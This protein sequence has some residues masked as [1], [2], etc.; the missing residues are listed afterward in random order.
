MR[1]WQRSLSAIVSSRPYRYF[2]LPDNGFPAYPT[3][4]RM[5]L[6]S[7]VDNVPHGCWF[8]FGHSDRSEYFN[9]SLNTNLWGE[10][11]E[12]SA[13]TSIRDR[14]KEGLLIHLETRIENM[15]RSREKIR[16]TPTSAFPNLRPK[17]VTELSQNPGK[18]MVGGLILAYS[19]WL[20]R[21]VNLY[22]WNI[23]YVSSRMNHY[24][25]ENISPWPSPRANI[26]A[27]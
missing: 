7:H 21:T 22:R 9:G 20:K 24:R 11:I 16:Y 26:M 6:F 2:R 13:C 12:Y 17:E 10:F 3:R 14:W 27:L 4:A 19:W 8:E 23:G 18:Q 25:F 15:V 1:C 5:V